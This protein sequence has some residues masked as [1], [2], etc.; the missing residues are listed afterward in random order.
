[1]TVTQD[2]ILQ[3]IRDAMANLPPSEGEGGI[4]TAEFV[5]ATGC[6][7]SAARTDLLRLIKAG[8]LVPVKVFRTSPLTGNRCKVPGFRPT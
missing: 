2:D 5:E 4:T 8:S 6:T 7:I 1:M 3:A